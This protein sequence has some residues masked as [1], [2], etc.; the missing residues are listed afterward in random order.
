MMLG[1]KGKR[2]ICANLMKARKR[3]ASESAKRIF[4]IV[5]RYSLSHDVAFIR[6]G[7][8]A[9]EKHEF[10]ILLYRGGKKDGMSRGEVKILRLSLLAC[11]H[12]DVMRVTRYWRTYVCALGALRR[13]RKACIDLAQL[14]A[15][16][17]I[18]RANYTVRPL[19][20]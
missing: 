4:D 5:T 18:Q 19:L 13:Y 16:D 6:D 1:I 15:G 10:F 20:A 7:N 17:D 3:E 14:F 8:C 12:G 9:A 11:F 2:L